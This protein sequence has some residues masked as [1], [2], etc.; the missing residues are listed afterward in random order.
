MLQNPD[1]IPVYGRGGTVEAWIDDDI[2][3]DMCGRWVAFI[4]DDAVYSFKGKLL[5]FYEHGWFRDHKGDAV[6]FIVDANEEG[7]VKPVCDPPPLPPALDCPPMPTTPHQLPVSP[8][9]GLDW[10]MQTWSELVSG[11]GNMSC[12]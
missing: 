2:V 10:S 6:T 8:M 3:F 1:L 11:A 12:Y 7:P 5:G 4:D 9:P